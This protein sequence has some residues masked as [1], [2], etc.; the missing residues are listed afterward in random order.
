MKPVL[1][2]VALAFGVYTLYAIAEVGYF[3]IWAAGF[4]SAG[5]L[6][7]LLDLVIACLLI[8]SWM[9]VD[10][11]ATGRNPWPYVLITLAAGSFG[12]LLYLL[13]SGRNFGVLRSETL[14][15]SATA[16]RGIS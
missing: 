11:R 2:L 5:A 13:L 1:I 9:V 6:Q 16:G 10:A 14:A 3:G 8:S 7:V 4:A 12:P 15:S